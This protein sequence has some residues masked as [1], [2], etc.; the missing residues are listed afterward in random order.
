MKKQTALLMALFTN[1]SSDTMAAVRQERGC[2]V[3][4]E[5]L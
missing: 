5:G 3:A 1:W 2:Y 4:L